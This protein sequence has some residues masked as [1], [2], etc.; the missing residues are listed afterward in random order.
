MKTDLDPEKDTIR[1]SMFSCTQHS[2]GKGILAHEL[3][4]ALSW[5]FFKYRLSKPSYG[6]FMELRKCANTLYKKDKS[7]R[8]PALLVHEGD[9]YRTEED[10]ADLISFLAIPYVGPLPRLQIFLLSPYNS[11]P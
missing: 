6:K 7:D 11:S 10:T 2:H 3:G 9:H 4:H 8:K 1:V 5:L